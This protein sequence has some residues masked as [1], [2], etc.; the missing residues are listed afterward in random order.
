MT[1]KTRWSDSP[2]PLVF[3]AAVLYYRSDA[4]QA[5]W[6]ALEANSNRD[7][8]RPTPT[9]LDAARHPCLSKFAETR[10]SKMVDDEGNL[11]AALDRAVAVERDHRWPYWH[12]NRYLQL[13][14]HLTI[15]TVS[16]CSFRDSPDLLVL[17]GHR[18]L[19]ELQFV[20]LT[21]SHVFE[22]FGQ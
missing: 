8:T 13:R 3:G 10:V 2:A 21:F 4:F 18:Q 17:G 1:T 14:P 15:A 20:S 7:W 22:H 5:S 19:L 9:T 12:D 16:N 6:P 11:L